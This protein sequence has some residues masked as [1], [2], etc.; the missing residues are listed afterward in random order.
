MISG[1]DSWT[2][3]WSWTSST[4]NSGK[5]CHVLEY[6]VIYMRCNVRTYECTVRTRIAYISSV[7]HSWRSYERLGKLYYMFCLIK[8][9]CSSAWSS[10]LQALYTHMSALRGQVWLYLFARLQFELS[11]VF[12]LIFTNDWLCLLDPVY[13]EKVSIS[14][15]EG[16]R[17]TEMKDYW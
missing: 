7:S 2:T 4:E 13:K 11:S 17:C 15:L 14:F 16:I 5:F 9:S 8:D 3:I 10:H 6:D 12:Q 1:V